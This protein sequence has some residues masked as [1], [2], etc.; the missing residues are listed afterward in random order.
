MRLSSVIWHKPTFYSE[1]DAPTFLL[2]PGATSVPLSVIVVAFGG[3]IKCFLVLLANVYE[4]LRR[5]P[6]NLGNG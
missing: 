5:T 3:R 4:G 1:N 6:T 2:L